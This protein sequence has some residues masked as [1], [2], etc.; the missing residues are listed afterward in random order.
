MK[1]LS[2]LFMF[3]ISVYPFF[4]KAQN[5]WEQTSGPTGGD[6]RALAVDI[7]DDLFAGTWGDG[8]FR[9]S[10]EGENWLQI[11]FQGQKI[12]SISFNSQNHIFVGTQGLGI[13]R[14]TDDGLVWDQINNGLPG[15]VI[16]DKIYAILI[17]PANQYIFLATNRGGYRSTDNG[18]SWTYVG[19]PPP[20]RA[21]SLAINS[22]EYIY[23]GFD[24]GGFVGPQW[25]IHVSADNGN[26]WDFLGLFLSQ[27]FSIAINSQDHIFTGEAFGV[28]RSTDLGSNWAP[29]N[30]GL[31][32]P[33][34]TTII[35]SSEDH[36]FAGTLG[37]GVHRSVDNGD[38]WVQVNSGLT[39]SAAYSLA[40][41]SQG[42]IFAG[43]N[44]GGVFR[45]VNPIVSIDQTTHSHLPDFFWAQNYP[46]PFN[47][48]TTIQFGLQEK[49]KVQITIYNIAGEH[50]ATLVEGEYP[51]GY[52]QIAF[53]ASRL[54]SG[55]YL[56][57][58]WAKPSL[59]GKIG[60]FVQTRRM[61]LLK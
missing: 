51:P 35:T 49:S 34:I 12:A 8:L 16:Q 52:H 45:S 55:M 7:N 22:Q 47:P 40:I 59:A 3:F 29:I 30:N 43:T 37:G 46:N 23:I 19:P 25:G 48:V 58:M 53:D 24:H 10:D 28:H 14:S 32:P 50:V 2:F 36:L 17:K 20:G 27:I 38:N 5:F 39:Y 61:L 41:N 9:S 31:T 26:N 15:D 60:E 42:Y 44:G 54:A 11:G 13:F 4:S 33:Y 56:Y 6:V 1:N 18:D 21:T 57:R